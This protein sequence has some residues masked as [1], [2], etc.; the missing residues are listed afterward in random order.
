MLRR[1]QTLFGRSNG[2]CFRTVIGCALDI[3][4]LT[5]PNFCCPEEGWWERF[6]AWC[7]A[8]GIFPIELAA[9]GSWAS[10]IPDDYLIVA[11]GPAAR[12]HMHSCIYNGAGELVW[13]PH[14]D[15]TGLKEVRRLLF[16]T[17]YTTEVRDE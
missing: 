6:E 9:S 8:R 5:L 16:F 11:S 12:G 3:E 17:H 2:D 13:D 14:P 7:A 1:H 10:W 4:P 15:G